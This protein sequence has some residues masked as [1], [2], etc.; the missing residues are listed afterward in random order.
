MPKGDPTT[1][2][3]QLDGKFAKYNQLTHG[4]PPLK[5]NEKSTHEPKYSLKTYNG[6]FALGKLRRE[7][8]LEEE[9][10]P[11]SVRRMQRPQQ[12]KEQR[13]SFCKCDF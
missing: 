10:L 7:G 4:P 5:I 11:L 1:V 2:N 3:I 6:K 9:V 12:W 13:A 8:S